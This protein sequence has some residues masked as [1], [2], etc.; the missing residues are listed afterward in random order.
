MKTRLLSFLL[1]CFALG[2]AWAVTPIDRGAF[3]GPAQSAF[4][5]TA[6]TPTAGNVVLAIVSSNSNT[7]TAPTSWG[8]WQTLISK[9]I[10][11]NG[12]YWYVFGVVVGASPTSQAPSVTVSGGGSGEAYFVE[13]PGL[14]TSNLSTLV[15]QSNSAA[16]TSTSGDRTMA[17]TLSTFAS[18]SNL[19]FVEK[20][21]FGSQPWTAVSPLT[22]LG[23]HTNTGAYDYTAT[24]YNNG[25]VTAP[26]IDGS[27]SGDGMGI[28]AME[29]KVASGGT[30]AHSGYTS[31]GAI[32]T[33]N[34]SSGS[35]LG[36]TG[37]FVTPDCSTIY[38]WSPAV[39]NFVLN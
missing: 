11:S 7:L 13:I 22:I 16:K 32:A 5:A 34:G 4:T 29:L 25:Q 35:Y 21:G 17:T 24:A 30:C 18:P 19:A 37:A 9:A 8:T 12:V 26:E 2:Q 23:Q 3:G 6:W 27:S 20:Y 33:P 39:G 31:G 1:V 10:D 38:Y 14:N 15:V 28:L 36:K